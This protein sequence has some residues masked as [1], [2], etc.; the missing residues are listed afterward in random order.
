MSSRH[1]AVTAVSGTQAPGGSLARV[2]WDRAATSM[3]DRTHP[4]IELQD[5]LDERLDTHDRAHV[6]AHLA[7]CDDCRAAL[8]ALRRARAAARELPRVEVPP[9]LLRDITDQ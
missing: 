1:R 2:R 5:L 6:E 8:D 9:T 4:D 7:T 3:T